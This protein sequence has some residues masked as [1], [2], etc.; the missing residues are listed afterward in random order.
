MTLH[1]ASEAMRPLFED[2]SVCVT[3]G[4]G[5]IGGHL[6]RGL[7]EL[8]ARVSVIDDLSNGFE[9][10]LAPV[11]S[12]IKFIRGNILDPAAMRAA[13]DGAECLFHMAALGSVPKSVEEP[14]AYH[15][16]DATG[17]LRVL[18]AARA[19][20]TRRF[21]YSGSSSAYGDTP[22]LPK[23]ETM[24]ADPRSPYA[25]A[26][27]AGEMYCRAFACCYGLESVTLRYFNIFGARQ[28]PDSQ[29]AAVIPRWAAAL[30]AGQR[31][32]VYGDGGQTRDF[33]HVDNVVYANLLAASCPGPLTGQTV[34]IGCGTRYSLLELLRLMAQCL[35]RSSDAE[36]APNRAGDVRDSEAAIAAAQQLIGYRVIVPFEEGL[37]QTMAN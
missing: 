25:V 5:F 1:P 29:Y 4:A 6:V 15:E 34:N 12:R 8:G 20:G 37:R 13:A 22:T 30:R 35:G 26:K 16:A 33:T 14:L 10:N 17:T 7:V 9:A 27:L 23:I 21:I 28:R 18:E 11:A 24:R 36:F 2:R 31:P 19:A 3:G 32:V